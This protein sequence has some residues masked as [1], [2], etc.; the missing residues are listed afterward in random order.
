MFGRMHKTLNPVKVWKALESGDLHYIQK[1]KNRGLHELRDTTWGETILHYTAYLGHLNILQ[2]LMNHVQGF[3]VHDKGTVCGTS[4]LHSA[5]AG[6]N[7]LVLR[8][9][10]GGLN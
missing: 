5:A 2:Y 1:S 10:L 9:S 4:L 8:Y 6:G 3:D 7:P